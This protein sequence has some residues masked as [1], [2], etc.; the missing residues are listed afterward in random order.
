[1]CSGESQSKLRRAE[2]KDEEESSMKTDNKR[3][4]LK[5]SRL[6]L[7]KMQ[8]DHCFK[9]TYL[10]ANVETVKYFY[11]RSEHGCKD[12]QGLR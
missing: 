12:C 6:L 2:E 7:A 8:G 1:M 3:R 11:F 9:Y 4:V 5:S 10:V